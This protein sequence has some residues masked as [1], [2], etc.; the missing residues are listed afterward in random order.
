MNKEKLTNNQV[1]F[2]LKNFF[3]E[4]SPGSPAIAE[5]LIRSGFCIVAGP[6]GIW[7]GGIGSFIK[8]TP[9]KDSFNCSL[10]TF[11]LD[12]FLSSLWYKEVHEARCQ[13]LRREVEDLHLKLIE[14]SGL[15]VE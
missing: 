3:P 2:L 14:I 7:K 13:D 9:A 10:Y 1:A 5:Q 8:V 15:V 4:V 12:L 11:D 6:H